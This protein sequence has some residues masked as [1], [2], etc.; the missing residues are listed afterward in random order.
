MADGGFQGA[1]DL[2]AEHI[3]ARPERLRQRGAG[4]GV[5]DG[6]RMAREIG[7]AVSDLSRFYGHLLSIDALTNDNLWP[8][9]YLDS[10]VAAAI[11]IGPD[12]NRIADEGKGGVYMANAVASLDDP[13]SAVV[14]FDTAIW[15]DAGRMG[16]I[17]A[18]PHLPKEGGTLHSADDLDSLAG[19]IGVDANAL[20]NTIEQFNTALSEGRT[21]DL[22]PPR[23]GKAARPIAAPP[24]LAAPICAGLTYTMGGIM[25]D[26]DGRVLH[27]SGSVIEGLYGVGAT[28]GGLEG[29]PHVGYVGGLAKSGIFGLRA[30]EHIAEH[31]GGG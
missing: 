8:Y 22:N 31:S 21:A 27:Q 2:V 4:T 23:T 20:R 24:F 28:T 25:T 10:V 30:A 14:L 26:P 11:V 3:T 12:G 7:A 5:G 13:L 9:P 6:L 17:P 29:G 19:R 15:Q 16:L 18:N 1:S